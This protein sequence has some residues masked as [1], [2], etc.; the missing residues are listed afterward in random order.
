MVL[1]QLPC[2]SGTH[3]LELE[4]DESMLRTVDALIHMTRTKLGQIVWLLLELLEKLS[5][6]SVS[7]VARAQCPCPPDT[8]PCSFSFTATETKPAVTNLHYEAVTASSNAFRQ[9]LA[10]WVWCRR[11]PLRCFACLTCSFRVTHA[12]RPVLSP[13]SAPLHAPRVLCFF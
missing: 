9:T 13:A 4:A 12:S 3:L 2:Y 8:Q 6:V 7:L 11:R 10:F 1:V 5:K